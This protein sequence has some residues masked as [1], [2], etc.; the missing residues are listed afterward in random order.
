MGG[1]FFALMGNNCSTP[2][3]LNDS[4]AIDGLLVDV[5]CADGGTGRASVLA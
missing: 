3:G 1:M 5:G 2:C 4:M